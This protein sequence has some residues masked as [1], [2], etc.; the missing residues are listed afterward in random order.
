MTPRS[1][2]YKTKACFFKKYREVK[3]E[4]IFCCSEFRTQRII[5]RIWK[6]IFLCSY[7]YN[8]YLNIL[9]FLIVI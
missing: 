6:Y 2:E 7:F 1:H 3:I 5:Y 4:Y 9:Q 8:I